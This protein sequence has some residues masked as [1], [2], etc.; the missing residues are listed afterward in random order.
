MRLSI[1]VVPGSSRA[2]ILGRFGEGW[3]LAVTAPPEKGKANTAVE[4]LLAT[5]LDLP[6]SAVTVVVG[7]GQP[8]K[9]VEIDGLDSAEIDRRLT[10]AAR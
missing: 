2:A 8:R 1:K 7:H 3:R 6:R 10:I 5:A 9:Q 4:V